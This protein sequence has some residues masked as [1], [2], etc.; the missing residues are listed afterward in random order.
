VAQYFVYLR[1]AGNL[2]A[3]DADALS[4]IL[5]RAN[6][7]LNHRYVV[8]FRVLSPDTSKRCEFMVKKRCYERFSINGKEFKSKWSTEIVCGRK[9]VVGVLFTKGNKKF[10]ACLCA[11]HFKQFLYNAVKHVE[12]MVATIYSNIMEIIKESNPLYGVDFEG[13]DQVIQGGGL[14]TG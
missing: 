6:D 12:G 5:A 3:D 7:Y 1:R 9:A 8:G 4:I 10:M 13:I 14:E 2:V 11:E